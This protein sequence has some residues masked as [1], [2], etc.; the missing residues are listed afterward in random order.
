[1]MGS[2]VRVTQA[3]PVFN[4]LGTGPPGCAQPAPERAA[5]RIARVNMSPCAG[6]I[7]P[8][9][10]RHRP[11]PSLKPSPRVTPDILEDGYFNCAM[12]AERGQCEERLKPISPTPR[13]SDSGTDASYCESAS[14]FGPG[15][16][17]CVRHPELDSG[18]IHPQAQSSVAGVSRMVHAEARRRGEIG[19]CC[20]CHRNPVTPGLSGFRATFIVQRVSAALVAQGE[21]DILA[22]ARTF[23]D[24]L[25]V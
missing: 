5:L 9:M 1:M 4:D 2:R 13:S 25:I 3:A 11:S 19:G 23:P 7:A 14:S 22:I 8:G 18:S 10:S 17:S 24:V 21:F 15:P 20:T 6:A 12:S 16:P